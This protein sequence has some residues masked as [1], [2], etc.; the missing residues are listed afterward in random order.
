[1]TH[2][3]IEL[4]LWMLVIFLIGCLLGFLLRRM[5]GS[6]SSGSVQLPASVEHRTVPVQPVPPATP[7][8]PAAP[9]MPVAPVTRVEPVVP[10]AANPAAVAMQAV[11]R[12][13]RPRGLDAPR[14]GKP[15]D[16]LLIRGIG[17]KNQK[18]L[19]TLGFFHFDQIA[20]W[21]AEQ[22]DWVDDHL[23]FNGRIGREEWVEQARL[24]HAGNDEEFERRFGAKRSK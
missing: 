8:E 9:V 15:D 16:L 18:I 21:T 3:M 1:M 19:H 7:S 13:E 4:A 5:F 2:Y 20:A 23:K 14:G 24:L 11:G 6:D 10:P 17:P 12:M 22:I